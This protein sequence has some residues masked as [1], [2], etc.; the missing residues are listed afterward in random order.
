MPEPDPKIAELE[1]RLDSLVRTQIDFQVEISAIRKELSRLRGPAPPASEFARRAD[2]VP[3]PHPTPEVH[4]SPLTPPVTTGAGPDGGSETR[5]L[6]PGWAESSAK[7]E[8]AA[9]PGPTSY[10]DQTVE[11]ARG[12]LE[13]FI[14]ENLISKVG[15]VVLILG[16]G[17]GTKYAIDNELISPL[18]RIILGYLF[19]IGLAALALRLKPKY[20]N[21]SAVLLSG[22]LASLYFITYFANASYG[23]IGR[24][25][26]FLLMVVF[27]VF[28]VVAALYYSRQVIAHF[29]LVGAYAVPFLLSSDTGQYAA[30][31]GYIALIN[32]GILA[33]SIWKYWRP[34][35]YTASIF[36]WLIFASWLSV[37]YT[38]DEHLLLALVTLGG[39]FAIFYATKVIHGITYPADNDRESL[40]SLIATG[41]IFYLFA[42]AI[43][44]FRGSTA[45][46]AIEFGFLALAAVAILLTSYRLFGRV[47]IYLAYPFTWITFG[48]WLLVHYDASS[49]AVMAAVFAAAFFLIFYSTTLAYRLLADEL[50]LAEGAVLLM[51]NSFVFY[52]AGYRVLAS[53]EPLRGYEGLYT[54]AHAAFHTVISQVTA[55]L[56]PL[57]TDVVQVLVVLIL[58]FCTIAVPVQF[59][60][61]V[62][63][64][65]WSVEAALL[66][67]F[68][69][70][71][72]I[73]LFEHL[74]Y[75]L[76]VLAGLSMMLDWFWIYQQR[77]PYV[78]ELNRKA[79]WNGDLV[80]A[81]VFVTC[82]AAMFFVNRDEKNEPAVGTRNVA[83][84]G[85]LLGAAALAVLYNS[86]RIEV[87]N[88]FHSQ[89]AQLVGP[90]PVYDAPVLQTPAARS[91]EALDGV[92]QI[93]YT[94]VFFAVLAGVNL[95]KARS[96]ALVEAV[97]VLSVVT[98]AVFVGPGM[99]MLCRLR[100]AYVD[101]HSVGLH[102][103][104][105]RYVTYAA[106]TALLVSLYFTSR[107]ELVTRKISRRAAGL[108]FE[109]VLHTTVFI[110]ASFEL[111]HLMAQYQI[112]DGTKLGLSILW[113]I[114]A[115]MLV[116]IGITQDKKYLRIAAIVILAVTLVK[117]FLYDVANLDTVPKTILF[118]SLGVL[119]LVVSFLY[120]KYKKLIVS[121]GPEEAHD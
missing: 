21:F 61:N 113:A 4:T 47:M 42:A 41:F 80:T 74:S 90:S 69:R 37:K 86:L 53:Y 17:I 88:Y 22:G 77:T 5:R 25:P 100:S 95:I 112:A 12:D 26:A 66:F 111:L 120:N 36:T 103:V 89:L 106:A 84:V 75:P 40:M 20:L 57:A 93:I 33:I 30:L 44:D 105:V 13:R 94:M 114:Y 115:L 29:G 121:A 73:R 48:Y 14:G 78:S 85:Y 97:S 64:L 72:G 81:L 27:T 108:I 58:T 63:T 76:M 104:S 54:V 109:S 79:F 31:F 32:S 9:R 107:D 49:H 34:V 96:R 116:V 117:L 19:S 87:D 119:M 98:L 1:A 60:G 68:G 3:A 55:R 45:Q 38:A 92:W 118:V 16:V 7:A 11:K 102:N 2:P 67:L 51:S 65:M 62:V 35:F 50:G 59:D 101:D 56:K 24:V 70:I 52:I 8:E 71:R 15:I 91:L 46:Y 39:F 110:T 99:E 18:A 43:S 6:P 83:A 28:A 10:V 82:F 23:L